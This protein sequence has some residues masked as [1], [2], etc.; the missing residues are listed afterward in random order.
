MSAAIINGTSNEEQ[1]TIADRTAVVAARLKQIYR[2]HVL[3]VEKRYQYDFF[4]ESPFLS[5]VE[6]DGASN[7]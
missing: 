1:T 5:D 2:K 4:F 7:Y 3:P 6:F